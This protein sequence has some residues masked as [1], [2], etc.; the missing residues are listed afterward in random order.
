[1]LGTIT[2]YQKHNMEKRFIITQ[3]LSVVVALKLTGALSRFSS[4]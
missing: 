2:E 1:M 3:Q 4:G